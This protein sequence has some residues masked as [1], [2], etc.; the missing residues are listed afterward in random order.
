MTGVNLDCPSCGD[1]LPMNPEADA[2][3]QA[4][5]YGVPPAAAGM[6][7]GLSPEELRGLYGLMTELHFRLTGGDMDELEALVEVRECSCSQE[8]LF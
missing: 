5:A 3:I 7:M 6:V 8:P 4:A 2:V 1:L